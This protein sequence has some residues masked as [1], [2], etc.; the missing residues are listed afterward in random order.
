ME[1]TVPSR[2]SIYGI[3]SLRMFV[4]FTTASQSSAKP[5]TETYL[6]ILSKILFFNISN[7]Y[8]LKE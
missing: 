3:S 4:L 1:V 5:G 2:E 6:Y 8:F 7:I